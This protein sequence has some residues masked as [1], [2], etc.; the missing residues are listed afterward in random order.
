[1][2]F[3]ALIV[4]ITGF[5]TAVVGGYQVYNKRKTSKENAEHKEGEQNL[6][7]FSEIIRAYKDLYNQNAGQVATLAEEN[8]KL[9]DTVASLQDTIHK[10]ETDLQEAR[11]QLSRASALNEQIQKELADSRSRQKQL[12]ETISEL[13]I[14]MKKNTQVT[15]RISDKIE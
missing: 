8:R 15:N 12:L 7:E 6:G 9:R 2:D 1:M 11:L 13:T 14:E 5:V 10:M 3:G 4:A